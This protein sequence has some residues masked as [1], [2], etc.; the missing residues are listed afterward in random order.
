MGLLTLSKG[1][2]TTLNLNLVL[3]TM[4]NITFLNFEV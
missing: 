2:F 4:M 1:F 3:D